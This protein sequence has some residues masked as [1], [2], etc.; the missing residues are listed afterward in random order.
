MTATLSLERSQ[1][2][3]WAWQWAWPKSK[4]YKSPVRTILPP[5][6]PPS[7]FFPPAPTRV[8]PRRCL[9]QSLR[10]RGGYGPQTARQFSQPIAARRGN[11]FSNLCQRVHGFPPFGGRNQTRMMLNTPYSLTPLSL[12]PGRFCLAHFYSHKSPTYQR[13]RDTLL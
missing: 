3:S 5:L 11:P 9:E 4:T 10:F 8:R 6:L 7:R 2:I 1:N 12:Y 13:P